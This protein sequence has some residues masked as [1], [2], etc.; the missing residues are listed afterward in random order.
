MVGDG[1]AMLIKK[2]KEEGII[3]DLVPHLVDDGVVILQY[4][5]DTILLLED[6]LENARNMKF[7]QSV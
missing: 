5:E 3:S 6:N 7:L 1:L 2:A 4:A